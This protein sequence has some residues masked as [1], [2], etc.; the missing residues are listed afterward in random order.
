MVETAFRVALADPRQQWLPDGRPHRWRYVGA[1]VEVKIVDENGKIDLNQGDMTLLTEFI[2]GAGKDPQEAA[3][4]AAA[5]LDWRDPDAKH[6]PWLTRAIG[7]SRR[8]PGA[9][10]RRQRQSGRRSLPGR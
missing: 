3:R 9:R 1:S 2:R 10:P 5:I 4:L 6:G 8:Q 7:L